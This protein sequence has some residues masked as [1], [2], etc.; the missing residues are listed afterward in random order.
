LT[1]AAALGAAKMWNVATVTVA[2]MAALGVRSA[3]AAFA[4][5]MQKVE[6]S[7]PFILLRNP[8]ETAGFALGLVLAL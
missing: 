2:A 4:H 1:G 8:L 6:G 5:R 3:S 7:S